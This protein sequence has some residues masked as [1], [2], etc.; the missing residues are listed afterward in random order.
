MNQTCANC[1][2]AL[3]IVEKGGLLP[4]DY[5]HCEVPRSDGVPVEA[6]YIPVGVG[7]G[8]HPSRWEAV[9]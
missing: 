8:H 6:W 7:C 2:H 4:E 5:R 1:G 9:K 3:P